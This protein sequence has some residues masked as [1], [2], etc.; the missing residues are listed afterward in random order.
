MCPLCIFEDEREGWRKDFVR[1]AGIIDSWFKEGKKDGS[2]EECVKGLVG[3]KACEELLASAG[4]LRGFL[5][6]FVL[7]L[8]GL[9]KQKWIQR[10][11]DD[12]FASL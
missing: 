4:D 2:F 8:K 5:E 10:L 9:H 1:A 6:K 12:A 7:E 11:I 3:G